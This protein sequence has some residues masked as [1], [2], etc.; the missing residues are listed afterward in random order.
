MYNNMPYHL[1]KINYTFISGT[2]VRKC[3]SDAPV[4]STQGHADKSAMNTLESVKI[5]LKCYNS[6]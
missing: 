3:N 6:I 2:N 5:L 1:L 4:L